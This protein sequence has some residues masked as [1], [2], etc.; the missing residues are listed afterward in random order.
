VD[1][2]VAGRGALQARQLDIVIVGARRLLYLYKGLIALYKRNPRKHAEETGERAVRRLFAV[3]REEVNGS[4]P[5][6]CQAF[7]RC[8]LEQAV[9]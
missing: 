2:H 5:S 1:D 8:V 6:F 7:C 9:A 3:A 4:P